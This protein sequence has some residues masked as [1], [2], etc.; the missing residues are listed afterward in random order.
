DAVIPLG[1]AF[2]DDG[3]IVVA[4]QPAVNSPGPT[5]ARFNADGSSDTSFGAGGSVTTVLGGSVFLG[6]SSLLVQPAG[7]LLLASTGSIGARAS[8][9]LV[10]YN[11]DG[12][13]DP[14]F[15]DGGKVIAN[16]GPGVDFG[17]LG[18][19]LQSDGKI[20]VAGAISD[21]FAVVRYNA[22]GSLDAS[23]GTGGKV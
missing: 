3:K 22:N 5:V 20:V 1:V 15:G 12:S 19:T 9:I 16:L 21:D 10:R 7:K 2:Q 6:A 23:F 14:S 4:T 8:H 18:A 13:L 17:T 11:G